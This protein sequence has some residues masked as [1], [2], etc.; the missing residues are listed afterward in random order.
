[1]R[2]C[3]FKYR[4]AIYLT[5]V[6]GLE[7]VD[8][9]KVFKGVFGAV[10]LTVVLFVV[11]L[12]SGIYI[13]LDAAPS[14]TIGSGS[15]T[16]ASS[17]SGLTGNDLP[18]RS[19]ETLVSESTQEE[20]GDAL[21]SDATSDGSAPLGVLGT[22]DSASSN[23]T[24]N[25]GA[26]NSP[27][28]SQ[29]SNSQ[30]KPASS[31]PTGGSQGSSNNN[32]SAPVGSTTPPAVSE[33]EKTYYPARDEWIIEGHYEMITHPATNGERAVYGSLCNTCGA[34]ISGAAAMHLKETHH[35]GYHEGIVGYESYQIS[36]E[37]S[38]QVWVDTSHW[39]THPAYW[40]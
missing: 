8:M 3:R 12:V 24:S 29:S 39:I 31:A 14:C 21:V 4:F 37:R 13:A 1:M 16:A 7:V 2:V 9:A 30:A 33:P 34:N 22:V 10:T 11:L 18:L 19:L 6:L 40:A 35:S 23:P 20:E 15:T 36:P 5:Y 25:A 32:G 26:S 17:G 38:E 28:G 27:A